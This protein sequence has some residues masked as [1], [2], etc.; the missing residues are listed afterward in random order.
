L[1]PGA[2]CDVKPWGLQ[3]PTGAHLQRRAARGWTA[4][5]A[6]SLVVATAGSASGL[7]LEPLL[8]EPEFDPP[9]FE[10]PAGGFDWR[11]PS[12]F[13]I[14]YVNK[15]ANFH[16]DPE[17]QRY[18][19][20][21]VHPQKFPANFNGCPDGDELA[22]SQDPAESTNLRYRWTVGGEA[23]ELLTSCLYEHVFPA[24]G[25]YQVTLDVLE[26]DGTTPV[27]THTQTV[28]IRDILVV[29]IGD[30]YASG[31]GN[32][33]IARRY[34]R[35]WFGLGEK[36]VSEAEW[37]D[38]RCHRSIHGGPAQAAL[39]LEARDPKTSVTFLSFACSGG[40]IDRDY[41][42]STNDLDPYG[43]PDLSQPSGSGILGPYRGAQLPDD[44][45]YDPADFLPSQL[46]QLTAALQ[47]P[48]GMQPREVDALLMSAGGNDMGFGPIASVCVVA[49]KCHEGAVVY[50]PQ[51]LELLH[52]VVDRDI[53]GLAD[54]YQRLND[55]LDELPDHVRISDTYITE[56][57]DPASATR[58]GG[59]CNDILGDIQWPFLIDRDEVN[60]ARQVVLP[61]LNGTLAA[62][63]ADHGWH[64]VGGI[65]EAFHGHGYCAQ[66][67]WIRTATESERLQGPNDK[68]KTLGTL[69]PTAQ[70]HRVIRDRLLDTILPRL[71]AT[72]PT[73]TQT[74]FTKSPQHGD[75]SIDVKAVE[76]DGGWLIGCEGDDCPDDD[77][78]F[79]SFTATSEGPIVGANLEINGEPSC[80]PG[81][82]CSG[83]VVDAHNYRWDLEFTDDGIYR[84]VAAIWDASGTRESTSFEVK[85]DLR[86]PTV[87]IDAPDGP[88][89]LGE[90]VESDYHCWD[91]ASGI[92]SCEGDA[93][94][95]EA[96][97][98]SRV[99]PQTFSVRA[100]DGAGHTTTES[101]AYSVVYDFGG[102]RAPV[103]PS[104]LVFNTV[105][106]G[107]AVPLRFSLDG[108][109][110][111][112]ILDRTP[113]SAAVGC[114][115][116]GEHNELDTA[117]AGSSGL[118]YDADS[119]T[120]N[121]VW[122]TSKNW[123]GTCRVVRVHLD[124]GT[125]HRAWFKFR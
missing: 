17:E 51:G 75:T 54:S 34:E 35:T 102:F 112:G 61:G 72:P 80:A 79:T 55:G 2:S 88:Y 8:P 48:V 118:S 67:N 38:E 99:G 24:Q 28:T 82:S 32:P 93:E 47:P 29:S 74:A 92:V 3:M 105:K 114:D 96:V 107:A 46:D 71:Y 90:H 64:L 53:A 58:D 125:T 10:A 89:L 20:D 13:A 40:T 94:P 36:L 123:A 84:V 57:P 22:R 98:T 100:T 119:D 65:A 7:P 116:Q 110:G 86:A 117:A 37:I 91:G 42:K 12:R 9:P 95:G 101:S 66:D 124:D 69:H 11:V 85:V 87:D 4:A 111:L 43:P 106:A 78:T 63:A 18:D 62:A 73:I 120:Y 45:G 30:S 115:A 31:E 56:Y 77:A 19:S 25:D 6:F 23:G 81:V 68:G 39:A 5:I 15:V 113:S 60:W 121:Y 49:H 21:Y 14:N 83:T 27:S 44:F 104:P 50:T 70:G 33:D 1:L 41:W 26:A 103:D 16:W 97:D 109:H 76:G 52:E 122:K 108:D 59:S